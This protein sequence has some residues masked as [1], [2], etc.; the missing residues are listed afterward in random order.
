MACRKCI[1]YEVCVTHER[2]YGIIA[3]LC[4]LFKNKADFAEVKH[5]YWYNID[6]DVGW[7][8]VGC[9]ECRGE[10]SLCDGE[11]R[12]DYCPYCG[13]KMDGGKAE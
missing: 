9:S 4:G 1:H 13:A 11:D 5:G 3:D 2:L 8:L 6:S 12:T 10:Y 7:E